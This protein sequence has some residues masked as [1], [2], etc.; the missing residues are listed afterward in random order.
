M[1]EVEEKEE[2]NRSDPEDVYS[3]VMRNRHM[4]EFP[5]WDKSET[6]AVSANQKWGKIAPRKSRASQLL[7]LSSNCTLLPAA[8]RGQSTVVYGLFKATGG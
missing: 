8:R 2:E 1:L 4:P 6:A 5:R 3:A 7:P